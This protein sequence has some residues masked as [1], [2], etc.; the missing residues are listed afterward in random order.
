MLLS[1]SHFVSSVPFKIP[2]RR[3]CPLTWS[4]AASLSKEMTCWIFWIAGGLL[5]SDHPLIS[6]SVVWSLSSSSES[7]PFLFAF[8]FFWLASR[9]FAALVKSLTPKLVIASL[10]S[11]SVSRHS[12]FFCTLLWLYRPAV[13]TKFRN[14]LKCYYRWSPVQYNPS[15]PKHLFAQR[16]SDELYM[17]VN[18]RHITLS[19]SSMHHPA[20]FTTVN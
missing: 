8:S 10:K 17:R 7:S 4:V 18:G 14:E 13:Q 5:A 11:P 1:R 3:I 6:C 15:F 12:E 19:H 20:A 9:N 2:Y 16:I